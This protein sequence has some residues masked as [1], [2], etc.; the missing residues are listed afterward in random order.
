[1]LADA[2][3]NINHN[4][5]VGYSPGADFSNSPAAFKAVFSSKVNKIAT[6]RDVKLS[7]NYRCFEYH[8]R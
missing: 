2:S 6:Y 1:M 3:Q 8:F 5:G 7:R 4:Y